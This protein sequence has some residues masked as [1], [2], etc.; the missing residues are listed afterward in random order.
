[1]F[2]DMVQYFN[3]IFHVAYY[4]RQFRKNLWLKPH[5]LRKIQEERLRAI[6]KYAYKNVPFYHRKFKS[7]G[8]TPDDIKSV[9]DLYRIPLTTKLEIQAQSFRDIVD[10]NVDLNSLVKGATSGSTGIPLTIFSDKKVEHFYEAIWMRAMLEDGLRVQDR[11]MIIADPRGFP[12]KIGL[13]HRL[14]LEKRKHISIFDSIEHQ[15]TLLR[16]FR[17]NVIKSYASSL[18]NLASEFRDALRRLNV[19]LL[20]SGAELLNVESRKL[21]S[22]AFG[23]ELFDFYACNEFGLLAWECK[24]HEGYHLNV[25]STLMEFLDDE[26]EVVSTNEKGRVVC[27]GLLNYVMPLI[28]YE[29][30]DIVVPADYECSC[31]I[32]LPL[33]KF[34]EG[35]SDDFLVAPNGRLIP[36]TVFFPYPF[37]NFDRIKQ[38]KVVQ[39]RKD[40]LLIELVLK[41][42]V[43]E[44]GFFE[45][46]EKKVKQL[47]GEDMKVEFKICDAI[48]SSKTGKIKKV[49]RAFK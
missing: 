10:K 48:P 2:S 32:I 46:A 8:I 22:S 14:G 49:I 9:N 24:A 28:R 25:D 21:I 5:V 19:R 44:N 26:G 20:F 3:Q 23:G 18:F 38:F 1:M 27:T 17:P 33:I 39:E 12:K 11:M 43:A 36:P 6:V 30:G 15:M 31:G 35:R 47:F 37:E 34:V 41:K 42:N 40:K 7:A 29:L 45:K 13:L 16:E 4:L